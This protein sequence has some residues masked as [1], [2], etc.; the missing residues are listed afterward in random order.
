MTEKYTEEW[1]ERV[2]AAYIAGQKVEDIAQEFGC[3]ATLP[4]YYARRAGQRLR[5]AGAKWTRRQK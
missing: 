4:A 1:R 3:N 5:L 2:A